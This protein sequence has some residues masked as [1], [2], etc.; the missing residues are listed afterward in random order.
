MSAHSAMGPSSAHRWM[1]CPGSVK[2]QEGLPDISSEFAEEG[3]RAHAYAHLLLDPVDAPNCEPDDED[4]AY[5][6]TQYADYCNNL[7]GIQAYETRVSYNDWVPGGWGTADCIV[8][9]DTILHVIDLKYGKGVAI[10]PEENE[11]GL[12]YAL[13]AFDVYSMII[14]ITK[15]VIHIVQPRL[16]S[17]LSW[18]ITPDALLVFGAKAQQCAQIVEADDAPLVPSDKA[19]RWCKAKAGCPALASKVME[20]TKLEFG[21]F[22]EVQPMPNFAALT[23]PEQTYIYKHRSMINDLMTAIEQRLTRELGRG[24]E[25]PGY[26]LVEGRTLRKWKNLKDAEKALRSIR[27]LRVMDY[28]KPP[29]LN[30]P[31]QIEK[32]IGKGHEIMAKHVDKP[33]GQPTLV[34]EAD[35][36]KTLDLLKFGEYTE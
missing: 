32:L 6:C 4:M 11:Q 7:G 20:V 35:K 9:D 14:D 36:R 28:M 21:S 5:Y 2:A 30:S 18:E 15:I 22:D 17:F 12:L 27:K 24:K 31:A 34:V 16:D 10:S 3:T 33:K 25:V 8:L 13:G 19:C 1:I 29:V 23:V 26:K